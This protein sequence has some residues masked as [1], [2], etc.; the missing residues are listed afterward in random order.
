MT[1]AEGNH[2]KTWKKEK[3]KRGENRMGGRRRVSHTDILLSDGVRPSIVAEH[4][5]GQ[6]DDAVALDVAHLEESGGGRG[7]KYKQYF[8][9]IFTAQTLCLAHLDAA[10][11]SNITVNNTRLLS[12]SGHPRA[13]VL[14]SQ[15]PLQGI[16]HRLVLLSC[17]HTL[18]THSHTPH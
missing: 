18:A 5:V 17:V 3:K 10:A 13:D 7:K 12:S 6:A 9:M 15:L 4:L 8:K 2:H 1:D 16:V 14:W 11:D